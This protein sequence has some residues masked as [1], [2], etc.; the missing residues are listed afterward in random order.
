MKRRAKSKV[1]KYGQKT[2]K[3]FDMSFF[4]GSKAELLSLI[5]TDLSGQKRG[6]IIATVNPEFVM[7]ASKDRQF[8]QLL[9]HTFNIVDGYG[10]A[11]AAKIRKGLK[12]EVIPGSELINDLCKM[13][14]NRG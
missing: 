8:L 12:I 5:A 9:Q 14:E 3:M 10:L 6:K 2:W 11:W 4:G 7:Q 1:L 13:A